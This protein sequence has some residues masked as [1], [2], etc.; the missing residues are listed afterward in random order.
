MSR[1]YFNRRLGFIWR[2]VCAVTIGS[3]LLTGSARAAGS[4]K[5]QI[6]VLGDS[7]T[8]GFGLAP[9]QGF[10][11]KLSAALA[12]K[13]IKAEIVNA[14]VSGDTTSGGLARLDQALA[15]KPDAVI[16][17]LGAN[18]ALR[19]LDPARARTNL[20]AMLTKIK[21]ASIPVLLCGMRAP[22]NW[23]PDYAQEF[24]GLYPELAARFGVPLY[25]FFL[26]GVALDPALNQADMLHPN[27]AGVDRI[28]AAILPSVAALIGASVP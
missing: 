8:A 11:A 26:E 10:T 2:L 15:Q 4:D 12:A 25:P 19:G 3:V 23:G 28:V 5:K 7:L 18:D 27:P 14:G 6:L 16:L 17:E 22:T 21:A 20:A 1:P 9:E 24:D 13:N